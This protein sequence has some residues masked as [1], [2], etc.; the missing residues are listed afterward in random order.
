MVVQLVNYSHLT[1]L[2]VYR[3]NQVHSFATK[4]VLQWHVILNHS[5][6]KQQA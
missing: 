5:T 2:G 3:E 4:H 6:R 1:L